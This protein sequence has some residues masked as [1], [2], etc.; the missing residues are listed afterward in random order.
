MGHR[1]NQSGFTLLELLG[2]ISIL[3]VL[4]VVILLPR[5]TV[6]RTRAPRIN[7]VNNQKQVALAFKV[8]ASDHNDK[9]PMSSSVTNGGT[10][11]LVTSGMTWVHFQVLSNE[12][13]TPRLLIC[14]SDKERI[15]A[16]GFSSN[17]SNTNISY[18]V[19]VDADETRPQMFL[20]GDR[21]I[22]GGALLPNRILSLTSNDAVRWDN[23]MHQ[24]QGNVAF[25]DGSVQQVT[26]SRLRAAL[27]WSGAVS[28]RLA[29]P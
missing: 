24:G 15:P 26:S 27:L 21:N 7:C 29:L 1:P 16:K 5:H 19:G 18:F 6:V 25:A 8:W 28:N 22:I 12:L 2:V 9:F 23:R 17:L 14:P 20:A 11:E 13:I 10:L 4:A 3:F